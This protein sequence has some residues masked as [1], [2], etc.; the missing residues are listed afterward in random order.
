VENS[1]IKQAGKEIAVADDLMNYD[2]DTY[3]MRQRFKVKQIL[4]KISAA[5]AQ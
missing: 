5:V 1:S 3:K 2:E 4:I